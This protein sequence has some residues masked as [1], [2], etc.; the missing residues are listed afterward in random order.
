MS[1]LTGDNDGARKGIKELGTLPVMKY[2][3]LRLLAG[4]QFD[5]NRIVTSERTTSQL[6]FTSPVN[7]PYPS[8]LSRSQLSEHQPFPT[9]AIQGFATE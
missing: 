7:S 3:Y 9:L 1:T 8:L 6:S 4:K 2:K 5:Q